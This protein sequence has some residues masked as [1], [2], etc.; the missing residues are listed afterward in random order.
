MIRVGSHYQGGNKC[1]FRVWAPQAQRVELQLLTPW[2]RLRAMDKEEFDYW[3]AGVEDTPPG[4]R[5]VYVLDGTTRRPDPAS[6]FQ[7]EGVHGPS[8]V[9][10]HGA[11]AWTDA[12]WEGVPLEDML[13]YELH[14]GTFTP[15][16]TFEAIIPR[17]SA[18]KELGVTAIE[19]MPVAQ[20]P[21]NRNWGYDGAYPYA[22][23][24][25]YG[26]PDGLKTLV[27]RVH[28][29][30]MS[31]ILD[32]VYNH[33]GPEGNYLRDF[34]PYFTDRYRTPWGDAINYDGPCSPPIRDFVIQNAL[35]WLREYHVDALRLDALHF[36]HDQSAKHV[37]Q[38][39]TEQVAQFSRESGRKRY[40]IGESDLDDVRFIKP[41]GSGGYGLDAQW[42]D[43]FHHSLHVLLTGE[44]VGYYQD[45][46]RIEQLAKAFKEGFVFSWQYSK[47]RKR[48]H[49]SS[50]RQRPARQF[51]VCAQNHDQVGNRMRGEPLSRIV[52]FE[53][54]KL[55]AGTLLLSPYV[56]LLFMGQEYAEN[57]PF[58][59][60]ISHS[61]EDLVAA[62]REGRKKEFHAST[63]SEEF[64]DPFS[65]QTFQSS[66]LDW[67]LREHALH[68]VLRAFYRYVVDLRKRVPQVVSK[69][70]TVVQSLP[71]EKLL[72]WHR[73]RAEGQF[74]CVMNF[75][76]DQ[77]QCLLRATE[78]GWNR[79]L[80]SADSRWAGPGS[81]LPD[82]LHG[83][84]RI[85]IQP[86]SI[87]VFEARSRSEALV[88]QA[89]PAVIEEADNARPT[90]D[91]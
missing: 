82:D 5:Y 38:E 85:P 16:G 51:V 15:E 60:F 83:R 28:H 45:F 36:I 55:A 32:V 14:V 47:Y 63:G 66:K 53:S 91:L 44:N 64:P 86:R 49:G 84:R 67:D 48:L 12:G 57:A 2:E 18:L 22:V 31:A 70:N 25:S 9:V 54:L 27:N 56:P 79:I 20:F 80:D 71:R 73:I 81:L 42:S 17:L 62:V 59:Y 78:A 61:S 90:G 68:E 72:I 50:S 77:Q 11:F 7:P 33:M 37:I 1:G 43:D 10:N 76:T 58:L 19:L 46:G 74:Q 65:E 4:S 30:S 3:Q 21:G 89:A 39:L 23:Q 8:E 6:H 35:Y 41:S 75:S 88:T 34:G 87:V 13:I 69:K 24:N 40:L 26:G 29:H 52:D